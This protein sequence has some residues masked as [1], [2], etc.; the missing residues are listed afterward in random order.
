MCPLVIGRKRI[1]AVSVA[2][3]AT[4]ILSAYAATLLIPDRYTVQAQK[5]FNDARQKLELMRNITIPCNIALTVITKQQAQD[6]WG[7]PSTNTPD[8]T[9]TYRQEKIY[10]G[11]FMMPQNETLVQT[12]SNWVANWV[13]V[14]WNNQIYVVRENFNPFASDAEGTFVHEFVHI[15]QSGLSS[16][17]TYDEDKAHTCLVEG[18]ASFMGDYYVNYTQAHPNVYAPARLLSVPWLDGVHPLPNTLIDLNYLPYEEGKTFVETLYAQGGFDTVNRAY[19]EGYNPSNTAQ[20]L[21]PDLYFDNFTAQQTTAPTVLQTGWT[22]VQTDRSQ[23]HNTYGE[24]FIEAMIE[25]WTNQSYAQQAS[26][27]WDG[28]CFTYYE[29]GM[30][31]LFTWNMT[32][33]TAQDASQFSQAFQTMMTQTGATLLSATEWQANNTTLTLTQNPAANG[34]IIACST[35]QPATLPSNFA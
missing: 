28:D 14:T 35:A 2:L 18:D 31:Y 10:K 32:W 27:G 16:P 33:T 23:D 9:N 3:A 22:L 30:D 6:L 11:L 25:R 26:A 20:I 7:K 19:S 15:W 29:R 5:I 24:A 4:L 12:N 8:L 1:I 21:H 13:A 17:T 34:T